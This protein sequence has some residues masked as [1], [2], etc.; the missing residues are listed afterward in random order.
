MCVSRRIILT[1]VVG[2]LL[3][4]AGT[5]ALAQ[6]STPTPEPAAAQED[7]IPTPQATPQDCA[8][9]HL[10][11]ALEWQGSPHA[12]AFNTGTF[13]EA[14]L[15]QRSN[16]MCLS[17]HTTGFV[18]RTSTFSHAGVACAACH[19]ETP[20]N[21]PPETMPIALDATV[22]ADCHTTTFVEWESSAH[23]VE[24]VTCSSC[25]NAHQST[26]KA[27]NTDALCLSCHEAAPETYAHTTHTE[28]A[29]VD[30]HY[31]RSTDAD[32]TV[33]IATGALPPSGHQGDVFT[34]SCVS[35]HG[36]LVVEGEDTTISD[37]TTLEP[38]QVEPVVMPPFGLSPRLIEGLMVGLG[39][40][41]TIV[42]IALQIR[43]R[44]RRS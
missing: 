15:N 29:C 2:V 30:C 19:G 26:L 9:C 21:H 44:R 3:M 11:A 40:G 23:G 34:A 36:D 5:S 32:M 1:L 6:D 8:A 14:W 17:C 35:C 28:Q 7:A 22:C 39:L 24:G 38:A 4:W 18:S 10:D 31:H 41:A 43:A 20:I 27:E 33:H 16:P 37:I 12:L 13:Q 42:T 25:H